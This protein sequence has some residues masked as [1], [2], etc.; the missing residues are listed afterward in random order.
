MIHE[1]V[2]LEEAVTVSQMDADACIVLQRWGE[3]TKLAYSSC[4]MKVS[5]SGPLIL[6][7]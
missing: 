3:F 5:P 7:L 2:L 4:F 1:A 6:L